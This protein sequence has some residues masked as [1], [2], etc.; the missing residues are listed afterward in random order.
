MVITIDGFFEEAIESWPE[1]DL[2]PQPMHSV[3]IL[4][5]T[6]LSGHEFKSHS[7]PTL[8]SY[9]TSSFIHCHISFWLPA[10]LSHHV[11]FDGNCL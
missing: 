4:Q 5:P 8:Q 10:F 7:E 3:Q 6:E 11:Y 2:S 1:W 9:S